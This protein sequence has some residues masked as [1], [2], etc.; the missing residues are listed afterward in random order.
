LFADKP[1][2]LNGGRQQPTPA[3]GPR[4]EPIVTANG[5]SVLVVED[6]RD[7]NELVGA[8]AQ[9]CGFEYRAALTGQSALEEAHSR[10]P[11]LVILDLMLPDVN[12]FEVCRRLKS[13]EQTRAVPIIM[14][15][16]MTGDENRQRGEACG[17]VDYLTKP[18]NPD[19]LIES[20]S[21]HAKPQH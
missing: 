21:R 2:F 5:K 19:Q 14:L 9:I 16:A 18:F 20:I 12:G 4:E 10:T 7:V 11:A 3:I 1:A 8:Y 13:D 6:D 15:T 17:A